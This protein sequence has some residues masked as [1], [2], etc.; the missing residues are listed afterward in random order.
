[1]I[2]E[3][4]DRQ[5]K[6]GFHSHVPIVHFNVGIAHFT[7]HNAV[8]DGGYWTAL[9]RYLL[10]EKDNRPLT[11]NNLAEFT[12]SKNAPTRSKPTEGTTAW[13]SS[14]SPSARQGFSGFPRLPKPQLHGPIFLRFSL[15]RS[16]LFVLQRHGKDEHSPPPPPAEESD[17]GY[18]HDT[19]QASA[20]ATTSAAQPSGGLGAHFSNEQVAE[21]FRIAVEE[22]QQ[23]E[24]AAAAA[25]SL[26]LELD[27]LRR[28]GEARIA[29]ATAT[30]LGAAKATTVCTFSEVP[31]PSESSTPTPHK[32]I[33]EDLKE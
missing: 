27:I 31:T 17:P 1:M 10:I 2:S 7:Y 23:K 5:T 11:S 30:R 21:P 13:S 33:Q 26:A 14:R 32:P 25:T 22:V 4:F 3:S 28:K 15:S 24:A 18:S 29:A 19:C 16:L 20:T 6:P 12:P 9:A 8:K